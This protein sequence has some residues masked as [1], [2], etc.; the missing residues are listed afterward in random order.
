MIVVGKRVLAVTTAAITA[1]VVAFGVLVATSAAPEPQVGP[2]G[3]VPAW[4]EDERASASV[5]AFR[6]AAAG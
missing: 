5:R 6:S 1:V 3:R 4:L 2:D